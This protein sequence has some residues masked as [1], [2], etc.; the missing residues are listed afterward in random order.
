MTVAE[1]LDELALNLM[2]ELDDG[3]LPD[4]LCTELLKIARRVDKDDSRCLT[5]EQL[6]MPWDEFLAEVEKRGTV[7]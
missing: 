1:M 5:Q 7:Q 6:D 2:I 3:T 4:E